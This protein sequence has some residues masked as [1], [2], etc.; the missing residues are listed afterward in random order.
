MNTKLKEKKIDIWKIFFYIILTI[1]VVI[2]EYYYVVDR[3]QDQNNRKIDVGEKFLKQFAKTSSI[4]G[5]VTNIISEYKITENK[6]LLNVLEERIS[7]EYEFVDGILYKDHVKDEKLIYKNKNVESIVSNYIDL[8]KLNYN[9]SGLYILNNNEKN[10]LVVICKLKKT[11]N[12]G[13]YIKIFI[14]MK[15]FV[16]EA[17]SENEKKKYDLILLNENKN[18]LWGEKISLDR[19]IEILPIQV[20]NGEY[21]LQIAYKKISYI[22]EIVVTWAVV[23]SIFIVYIIMSLI[24]FIITKKNRNINELKEIGLK[25][26]TEV[27]KR[28]AVEERYKLAIEASNDIIWEYDAKEQVLVFSDNWKTL[29]DV[30]QKVYIGHISECLKNICYKEYYDV[31]NN[32]IDQL[33]KRNLNN[34][35]IELKG[36]GLNGEC[37]WMH[38]K[39]IVV[40]DEYNNIIKIGGAIT[41]ITE[42]KKNEEKIRF[43]AYNDSLTG[44]KNS[45]KFNEDLEKSINNSIN[46]GTSGALLFLDLDDFKKVNDILGHDYG[47]RLLKEMGIT[48]SKVI[49]NN[50]DVYRIA[51]DEFAIIIN[52]IKDSDEIEK[53]AKNIVDSF[54]GGFN[55]LGKYII[56]S[57]SLGISKFPKDGISAVEIFK[58][59]DTAMYKAKEE[60]KGKYRFFDKLISEELIKKV[61][62]ENK[63]RKAIV[64]KEFC[65]YYQ[66][67]INIK[68]NS[69]DGFEALIRWNSSEYKRWVSPMEFI[70]IAEEAGFISELGNLVLEEVCRNLNEWK[71]KD[72][73]V[74]KVAINISPIQLNK[75]NFKEGLFNLLNLYNISP[76]SI[77][78][79]MTETAVMQNLQKNIMILKDLIN[80]GISI[81]LDDFG[82]GYSSLSYLLNLPITLLKIDRCF[83]KGIDEK[84]LNK[85]LVEAIV[86]LSHDINLKVVAEGVETEGELY[87]L[88]EIDCDII[89]GYYF[90][91]PISKIEVEDF[92]KNFQELNLN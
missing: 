60:G 20:R 2:G 59:A 74:N 32:V 46:R 11:D 7:K 6:K 10:Q 19:D 14:D 76:E 26:T 79:E 91:K 25:L 73:K 56:T 34:F 21:Y 13:E 17:L 82:T 3:L 67:K 66:P 4:T 8:N 22:K 18:K 50:A 12:L 43:L 9:D 64:N 38:M 84:K 29:F 75:D 81:A 80:D 30:S 57:V 36:K 28:K 52:D 71:R 40:L 37:K 89:Q 87:A 44:L 86:K 41:D 5:I 83:I 48:I 58:N 65:V 88:K 42:N 54:K 85:G 78:L 55:I 63:I 69:I 62:M 24:F 16:N 15:E 72:I 61:D 68:S 1:C 70:P 27:E 33:F 53:T 49:D 90:S 39:G 92:V 31:L 77:E 23:I 45:K 35:K 47:D 51:G